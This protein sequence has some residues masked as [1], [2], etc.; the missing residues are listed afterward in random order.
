METGF[1]VLWL[2]AVIDDDY[3]LEYTFEYSHWITLQI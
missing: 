3:I 1:D 2:K